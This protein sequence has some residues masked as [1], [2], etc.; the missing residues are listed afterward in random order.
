MKRHRKI[1]LL[2]VLSSVLLCSFSEPAWA[3][4]K[5]NNQYWPQGPEIVS[6]SGIVIEVDT[7]TVL[8]EK[9]VHDRHYP[10]SITKIM[11]TLLAIENSKMDEVVTFSHDSVYN[12]EGSGIARDVDE[13]MTMEQC[14]YAVM[15]ASANECAYAEIGR[16]HV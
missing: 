11:T 8:Y 5:K 2:A 4:K 12:T 15:L 14:L 16:A 1:C 9:N 13:Q 3:K 6:A 10:A 7:G